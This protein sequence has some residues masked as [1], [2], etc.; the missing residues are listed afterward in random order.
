[1]A[2]TTNA[3]LVESLVDSCRLKVD[4]ASV[5]D[6]LKRF[7]HLFD[8]G[9][10]NSTT[11]HSS[12]DA[13]RAYYWAVM[14]ESVYETRGDYYNAIDCARRAVGLDEHCV[15]ARVV[16]SRILLD[17]CQ[18]AVNGITRTSTSTS[19]TSSGSDSKVP[20]DS[21]ID[22]EAST[23]LAEAFSGVGENVRKAFTAALATCDR[24][25]TAVLLAVFQ[26]MP[27]HEV[28]AVC[29]EV[30][31]ALASA[32]APSSSSPPPARLLVLMTARALLSAVSPDDVAAKHRVGAIS[33]YRL[34]LFL[35]ALAATAGIHEA[36][37]DVQRARDASLAVL[38]LVGDGGCAV[39]DV[40]EPCRNVVLAAACRL[41]LL[42]RAAG[43]AD[44]AVG[45]LHRCVSGASAL[46]HFFPIPIQLGLHVEAAL[47][48]LARAHKAA[49]PRPVDYGR[50]EKHVQKD[51]DRA[52]SLLSTAQQMMTAR[53]DVDAAVASAQLHAAALDPLPRSQL[54]ALP[55]P[56]ATQP[57]VHDTQKERTQHAPAAVTTIKWQWRQHSSSNAVKKS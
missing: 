7:A 44:E 6:A 39:A 32:S 36:L 33:E 11:Q 31:K 22:L 24:L 13:V 17:S 51:I 4:F 34:W 42:E 47:M 1:M 41:A 14:S 46:R 3:S 57:K 55:L 21:V 16:V 28:V 30:A 5:N 54:L 45:S 20:P 53:V 2:D 38:Y 15:E 23:V 19:T 43:L 29:T 40:P 50:A 35:D 48:M 10:A 8:V 27:G 56:E 12:L 37:G 49:G 18:S 25:V 9:A 52:F 26:F